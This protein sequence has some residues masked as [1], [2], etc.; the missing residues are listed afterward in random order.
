LLLLPLLQ[1]EAMFEIAADL[2]SI[3][4]EAEAGFETTH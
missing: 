2:L 1:D 3:G 4:T